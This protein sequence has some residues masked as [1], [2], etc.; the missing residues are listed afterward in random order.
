MAKLYDSW[1]PEI[2]DPDWIVRVAVPPQMNPGDYWIQAAVR[3]H[4]LLGPC[5]AICSARAYAELRKWCRESLIIE[6][7]QMP[8]KQAEIDDPRTKVYTSKEV[9]EGYIF[10]CSVDGPEQ[11]KVVKV[12]FG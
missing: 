7:G 5:I 9:V 6:T 1:L 12:R 11:G 3:A 2:R 8:P 4:Y 10:F